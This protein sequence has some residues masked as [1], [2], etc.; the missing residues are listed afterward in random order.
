MNAK[1]T[2]EIIDDRGLQGRL[3]EKISKLRRLN[4]CVDN[5]RIRQQVDEYLTRAFLLVRDGHEDNLNGGKS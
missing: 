4:D 2:T 1:H 3:L 5:L